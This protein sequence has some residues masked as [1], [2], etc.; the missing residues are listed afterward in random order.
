VAFAP[1]RPDEK[2]LYGVYAYNYTLCGAGHQ[3]GLRG[4]HAAVEVHVMTLVVTV[5]GRETIWL[6][7]D[8]RL[9]YKAR[10]PKEDGRKVMFLETTDGVAILGYAGLGATALGTEPA[11]WMSAVLRGRNLPLE[12]SLGVLAEATK[13]QLPRHLVRISGYGSAAHNVVVTAFVGNEARLYTIDLVF[14]PDRKG[15]HFRYTR[16]VV[17]R[18]TSATARPPRLAVGG[19]GSLYLYRQDKK[20][21]RDLLRLVAASE[22]GRVSPY[23]VADHLA[24]LN[25]EVHLGIHD[26]SVGPRC[27]V[28]WRHRKEGIHGGGGAHQFYTG[29]TRDTGSPGLP[30]ISQGMDMQALLSVFMPHMSAMVPGEPP[31]DV[32]VDE[33]NRELGPLPDKPDENLR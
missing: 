18:P 16:H 32:D 13:N 17:D 31:P 29:T 6:L 12:Q 33:L 19:T 30:T 24:S 28:A 3:S 5:N 2:R 11:D 23:A 20:W 4:H 9:S 7:A 8:R 15:Y 26:K 27:I 21:Q 14:T 22:R 25:N 10:S 1:H